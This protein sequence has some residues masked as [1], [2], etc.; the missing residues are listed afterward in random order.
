MPLDYSLPYWFKLR[1]VDRDCKFLYGHVKFQRLFERDGPNVHA[2]DEKD[3][4]VF[5]AYKTWKDRDG[6]CLSFLRLVTALDIRNSISEA[7]C[8]ISKKYL[9]KI[10][11]KFEPSD[12]ALIG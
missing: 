3:E 8:D 5:K 9:V 4:A 1:W 11:E 10:K 7:E 2:P 6:N 12:K